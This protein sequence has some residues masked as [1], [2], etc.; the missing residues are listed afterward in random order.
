M[1]IKFVLTIIALCLIAISARDVTL[2]SEAKAS[3]GKIECKGE[4]SA[5]PFGGATYPGGYEVKIECE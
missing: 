3:N 4:L 1:Y 2:V 5:S